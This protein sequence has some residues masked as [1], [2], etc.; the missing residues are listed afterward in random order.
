MFRKH[1]AAALAALLAVGACAPCA[2][3]QS[4]RRF[5]KATGDRGP[6]VSTTEESDAAEK[7]VESTPGE[8]ARER[9]N[10]DFD[11][12]DLNARRSAPVVFAGDGGKH[13]NKADKIAGAALLAYLVFF[14]IVT[15]RSDGYA[16]PGSGTTLRRVR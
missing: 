7:S 1:L 16:P 8:A 4:G 9:R 10:R 14:C 12:R 2:R 6:A 11:V 3:A 15:A 13:P 5:P